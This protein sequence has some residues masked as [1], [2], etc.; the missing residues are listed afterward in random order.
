[1][2]ESVMKG[3]NAMK[4]IAC[5]REMLDKGTHFECSKMLCDYEETINSQEVLAKSHQW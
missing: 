4:C 3:G 2:G 1:M 5:G